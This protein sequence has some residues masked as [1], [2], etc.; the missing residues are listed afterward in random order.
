MGARRPSRAG[1]R[2]RAAGPPRR[3]ARWRRSDCLGSGRA[4]FR[5]PPRGWSCRDHQPPRRAAAAAAARRRSRSGAQAARPAARGIVTA[6]GV[7]CGCAPGG[8]APSSRWRPWLI[9]AAKMT[10]MQARAIA[11]AQP[12]PAAASAR[13]NVELAGEQAE[14]RQARAGRS[15]RVPKMPPSAGR[16]DNRPGTFSMSLVP[17]A[18]RI[19]PEAKEQ[20][21][22][23]QA[24]PEDVQ[25]HGG[26]R[27]R[28]TGRGAQGDQ[29][30]V[31]DAVRRRA[32]ACNP[33]GPSSSD[34]ASR[35]GGQPGGGQ[36]RPREAG[37][38]RGIGD[39][40]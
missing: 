31:L 33:A 9:T 20:H 12:S 1:T 24:V 22:L 7:A 10:A 15:G 4:R 13:I 8:A 28:G 35:E 26:D 25:Q 18:S 17:S 34:A 14:R 27:Q 19:S 21:P 29:A 2:R 23:G 32:S 6:R 5:C 36:Q 39:R 3:A 37:A 30:H 11:A 40:P 38:E 16:R